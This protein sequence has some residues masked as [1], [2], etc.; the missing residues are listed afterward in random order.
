MRKCSQRPCIQHPS[1]RAEFT[2]KDAASLVGRRVR[3]LRDTG[4]AS[5]GQ[6]GRVTGNAARDP[7]AMTWTIGISWDGSDALETDLDWFDDAD[8][9]D[10][11][12]VLV[13]C[14]ASCPVGYQELGT[15]RA[16]Q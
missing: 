12:L 15:G 8:A 9:G 6:V 5:G 1:A 10:F 13:S 14:S 4:W 7:N 11:I 3:A 16:S 2:S